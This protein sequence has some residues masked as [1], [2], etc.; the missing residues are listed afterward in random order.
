MLPSLALFLVFPALLRAGMNFWASLALGCAV[1]A[2]LYFV[3]VRVLSRFGVS[4]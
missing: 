2:G 4:L 1:T 3:T